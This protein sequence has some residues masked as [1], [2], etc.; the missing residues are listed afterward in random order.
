MVKSKAIFFGLS[1][2]AFAGCSD[3]LMTPTTSGQ[4]FEE[5]AARNSFLV[6]NTETM[7][8]SPSSKVKAQLSQLAAKCINGVGSVTTITSGGGANIQSG[9]IARSYK[10]GV[11]NEGDVDRLVIFLENR[12]GS[13]TVVVSTK[14][15]PQAD[16]TTLLST[17]HGKT[18]DLFHR[19]AVNW[20]SRSQTGCPQFR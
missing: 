13:P 10:A 15:I 8:A 14:I 9:V 18:F 5:V 20:A 3:D 2:L 4:H 17:V 7:I 19:A 6:T 12:G 16:G 11:S 1:F